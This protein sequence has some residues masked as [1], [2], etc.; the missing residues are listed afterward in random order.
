M[1]EQRVLAFI[2]DRRPVREHD[3]RVVLLLDDGARVEALAPGAQNSRRRFMSGLSPLSLYRVGITPSAKGLRLD[4]AQVERAWPGLL[5]SLPRQTAAITATGVARALA[6]P[7]SADRTVFLLLGELYAQAESLPE[8]TRAGAALVRFVFECLAHT[9]HAIAFDRCVRCGTPA[10]DN[11][12][13][14]LDP[15]AGGVVCRGCGGGPFAM[16]ASERADLRAVIAGELSRWSPS[17][18]R[19]TARLIEG[20]S[21]D[22]AAML[23][24]AAPVFEPK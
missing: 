6:E 8:P 23:L 20:V 21:G 10:P 19:A 7:A 4:D 11:A 9:G 2:L 1:S 5:L 16:S 12:R 3:L 18:L 22:A 14:T 17:M 13:V 24:R 15:L